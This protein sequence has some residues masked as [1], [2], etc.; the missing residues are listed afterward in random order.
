[1][2]QAD[3]LSDCVGLYLYARKNGLEKLE[4][5]A[6]W[7]VRAAHRAYHLGTENI[8]ARLSEGFREI[9]YETIA[10]EAYTI[11][12]NPDEPCPKCTEILGL[13]VTRCWNNT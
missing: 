13:G 5:E 6:Y 10:N 12:K 8:I 11:N 9:I 4:K 7:K 1:M 3:E 2:I